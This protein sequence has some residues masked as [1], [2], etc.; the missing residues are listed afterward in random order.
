VLILNRLR[1][2]LSASVLITSLSSCGDDDKIVSDEAVEI[3]AELVLFRQ[4][5]SQGS[6]LL[7]IFD[8]VAASFDSVFS[9]LTPAKPCC[10]V[11]VTCNSYVL[12]WQVGAQKHLY[13]E[14]FN[15]AGFLEPDEVYIFKVDS[16]QAVQAFEKSVRFPSVQPILTY[17]RSYLLPEG[18]DSVSIAS[19][20]TITWTGTSAEDVELIVCI[21]YIGHYPPPD[22]LYHTI[23]ENDGDFTVTTNDLVNVTPGAKYTLLLALKHSES[24]SSK[25]Y[26]PRSS[27]S[28]LFYTLSQFYAVE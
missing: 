22:T 10:S 17:P 21:G 1:V 15:D 20:F 14:D 7:E 28:A 23:T 25:G 11:S 5:P 12:Q 16:G 24:L 2:I 4:L 3:Y 13:T 26:D 27:V 19:G 6:G 9:P 8:T 18:A